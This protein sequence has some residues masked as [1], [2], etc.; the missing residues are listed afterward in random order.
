MHGL[1]TRQWGRV[2][3]LASQRQAEGE[4]QLRR[5][6]MVVERKDLLR[7]TQDKYRKELENVS[8]R[9]EAFIMPSRSMSSPFPLLLIRDPK[10]RLPEAI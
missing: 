8:V 3:P 10:A 9:G 6:K 1:V 4:A 2:V 5:G 7:V